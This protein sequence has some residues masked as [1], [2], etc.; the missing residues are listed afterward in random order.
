MKWAFLR[1][2]YT[3]RRTYATIG[4]SLRFITAFIGCIAI[5]ANTAL[6]QNENDYEEIS[7]FIKIPGLSSTELPAL[8]KDENVFLPIAELFDFLKIKNTVS[9]NFDSVYGFFVA[10]EA[11]YVINY[12]RNQVLYNKKFNT[13]PTGHFI[14]TNTNLYMHSSQ[15]GSIFGLNCDFNFRSLTVTIKT[16]V[17]LPSV[18]E[19][20]LATMRKNISR[21]KG[22][23]PADTTIGRKFTLFNLGVIDWSVF[24]AQRVKGHNDTRIKFGLGSTLAGGEANVAL[25]INPGMPFAEKQQ[26]YLWRYVNNKFPLLRQVSVGRIQASPVSSIFN[27]LIGIQLTNSSTTARKDFGT[28]LISNVT[29][30]GWMVELYINGNLIDYTRADAT[31]Y[32]SF[33]VPLFYGS[34]NI[35]LRYYGPYGEEQSREE[36]VS[37]PLNF[38][39]VKK[40]EYTINGAFVEDDS[41]SKFSRSSI[42]YGLSRRI[43]VGGGVEYLSSLKST[44]V[45]PFLST[46]MRPFASLL[47]NAQYVHNVG[48]KGLLSYRLPSNWQFDAYYTTYKKGQTAV[49]LRYLEER[50]AVVTMPIKLGRSYLFSML[51]FTHT[52]LTTK[53][54]YINGEWMMS[55]NIKGIATRINTYGIFFL[56]GTSYIYSNVALGFKL[57]AK[58]IFTPQVQYS[59]NKNEIISV[60]GALDKRISNTFF[61][62]ISYQ[63]NLKSDFDNFGFN[64]KYNLPFAQTSFA[65]W[66]NDKIITMFGSAGG[67]VVLD[68]KSGLA[69][70]YDHSSMG[71][72]GIILH[73]FLDLNCNGVK[74][75]SEP[76][77]LSLKFKINSTHIEYNKNDSTIR[78]Y[79]LQPYVN[80]S[81]ELDPFS[82]D[83]VSWQMKHK[84]L[85]VMAE[86]NKLKNIE[87]PIAVMGEATGYVYIKSGGDTKGQGQVY[88]CI[89]DEYSKLVTRVLSEPDGRYSYIGLSPGTYHIKIDENQLSR[90]NMFSTPAASDFT[91]RINSDGDIVENLD[92]T[93]QTKNQ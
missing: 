69:K 34:S 53:T 67:S 90:L 92:F 48:A 49:N 51:T 52:I 50:K 12:K 24:T 71:K 89:Y 43:T 16:A 68:A 75:K 23:A 76:R 77:I 3:Q 65:T 31:G 35:K 8:I 42:D 61:L 59:F 88:I 85:S 27:P 14:K 57:P 80:Y 83:N 78:I 5:T 17:E 7:V 22:E 2:F 30:P 4:V 84:N 33:N 6:A 54:E 62:G 11:E 10:Q 46:S 21:L 1:R 37:I 87:V 36:N 19:M 81:I 74:E 64:L 55:G 32:F 38:V 40:L 41:N 63:K 47:V 39:P 25:N 18:K 26:Y 82:F 20:R 29:Q 15:F 73:P 44:P 70:A 45:M 56:E 9:R 60:K 13:I 72:A 28:F 91:I 86:A 79:D 66:V 93:I 58:I